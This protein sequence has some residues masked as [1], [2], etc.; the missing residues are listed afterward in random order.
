M[1]DIFFLCFTNS[2]NI[3]FLILLVVFLEPFLKKYF[4]AV[5]LYRL[6]VVLLIG[7]LI[8]MRFDT[9]KALFYISSSQISVENNTSDDFGMQDSNEF[10]NATTKDTLLQKQLPLDTRNTNKS[11]KEIWTHFLKD[12]TAY[13]TYIVQ[14]RYVLL[15]QL[16]ILGAILL[17]AV[18]GIQHYKYLKG[19]KRFMNP[20]DQEDLKE[21]YNLCIQELHF[22]DRK[23]RPQYSKIIINKCSII[24]SPMTV[25]VFKPT[26]LFPEE[27]YSNQDFYFILKHELI[28]IQRRDSLMKLVRLIV[29]ALNWYNPFCYVLSRHL[30]Q[31][32]ETSCDELVINNST[33]ADCINYSK[34]LLK[35][36]TAKRIATDTI[37][38]IGGKDNMKYRLHLIMDHRKKYSGKVL[39]ALLLCVV[40]TTVIVSTITHTDV[41]ASS[42]KT[43]TEDP[44]VKSE[45]I[46]EIAD[47]ASTSPINESDPADNGTTDKDMNVINSN[48]EA[49][50]TAA[51]LREIV[52][53]YA[54]QE[55]GTPYLWGGDE[56]SIGVDSSGFTQA[57]YKKIGYDLPRTSKEQADACKEASMDSLQEGDLIFYATSGSNEINHVGIYIGE[58]KIIHAK[59]ARDGVTVQDINYRTPLSAGRIITD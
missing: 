19:L 33:R 10:Y 52:V 49:A 48:S 37:N 9:S 29:L 46:G 21:E 51:S 36:T 59:N 2:L 57:I 1:V 26:I 18:K 13:I 23:K 56:L 14:Y 25:G 7:L 8:P 54:I 12:I 24:T 17:L 58:D 39:V 42:E 44:L 4:S 38:M 45:E 16:W 55:E 31:W 43:R 53:E 34:L 41:L 15:S 28:H 3:T 50:P 30:D 32:C 27:S 47:N 40:F 35:Y 22:N 6:W 11:L 5:C 20:I